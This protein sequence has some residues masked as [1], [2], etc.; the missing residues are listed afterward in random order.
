MKCGIYSNLFPMKYIDI[1]QEKL[2]AKIIASITI[3]RVPIIASNIEEK[4]LL[5]KNFIK[6]TD[7]Y[8][9]ILTNH[10]KYF[11][12][13]KYFQTFK[14][15]YSIQGVDNEFLSYLETKK[16]NMLELVVADEIEK[17]Y[18]DYF[19]SVRIKHGDQQK[20]E[21]SRFVFHKVCSHVSTI[22]VLCFG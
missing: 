11:S 13:K 22:E 21:K 10:E 12:E 3:E 18:F 19:Y 2:L 5:K 1:I 7:Y 8:F 17:L 4:L 16:E 15:R 20:R 14:Q 9:S 6:F